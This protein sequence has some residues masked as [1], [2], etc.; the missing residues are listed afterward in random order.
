MS[1]INHSDYFVTGPNHVLCEIPGVDQPSF[2]K[3]FQDSWDMDHVRLACSNRIYP[4]DVS[5]WPKIVQA[6]SQPIR[7]SQE[8]SEV[9]LRWNKA[10][11]VG[12]NFNALDAFLNH[13]TDAELVAQ[14]ERIIDATT[15]ATESLDPMTEAMA[16]IVIPKYNVSASEDEDEQHQPQA[17][18]ASPYIP[19]ASQFLSPAERTRFF[20]VILPRMQA[21][22]LRLPELIKKPIPFLKQQQDSAI[23]LSQEQIACLTANAFFNTFPGRNVPY[24]TKSYRRKWRPSRRHVQLKKEQQERDLK[25][26]VTQANT[27]E[28]QEE[29]HSDDSEDEVEEEEGSK[30]AKGSA[31]RGARGRGNG[32]GGRG[33]NTPS[34]TVRVP[35]TFKRTPG[36]A[37][38]FDFV[39]ESMSTSLQTV[40]GEPVN[41]QSTDKE[42]NVEELTVKDTEVSTSSAPKE[43]ADL[44]GPKMPSI[45]LVSMFWSEQTG[46]NACTDAQAAKLRCLI[47][48]F[49]RVTSE[50]DA[51]SGLETAP[52]GALQLDF[53]N[54]NI[55]GGALDR[56]AVQ[57]EIR[58]MICPEMIV[59]RLFSQP[60]EAN[61][62][63]LIKGIEQYSDYIG[64]SKTFEWFSDHRDT[65]PRDKLGRRQR[66]IC[67][68]DA[69]PFK[70][71]VSRIGQFDKP[72][73]LREINKALAGFR[74]SPI[75]ASEWGLAP[76]LESGSE[77]ADTVSTVPR[78]IA[79]G[80]WGCGAFGG[81]LQLKF[82]LQWIAASVSSKLSPGVDPTLT[83]DVLYYTFGMPELA[84][85][86]EAFV[87]VLESKPSIE[88]KRLVERLVKYPRRSSTGEA[89]KLREKGLLEY[90]SSAVDY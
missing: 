22:A 38:Q 39:E 24:K 63:I 34:A 37:G 18:V 48:Y 28:H 5:H 78:A 9:I 56:G 27:E 60:M 17:P 76:H 59:S 51:V 66:E 49:D 21:L 42:S 81:H 75:N 3:T 1:T 70:S 6:L 73:V 31:S 20:D 46:K 80:N 82:V 41:T 36:P 43:E 58:F 71:K 40:A 47:H 23:T 57:E 10:K 64:Y 84:R 52:Q 29:V 86:I 15:P 7:S 62:A 4:T 12:W 79:T 16:N 89:E 65:T 61:E 85:D 77:S 54:K 25:A 87:K 69:K 30:R 74:P 44:R 11:E 67:A 33:G 55:G 45:N 19:P 53:A 14:A 72:L 68:I 26:G 2:P 50:M 13:R 83:H 90:L 32:R 35:K 8:L 88:P